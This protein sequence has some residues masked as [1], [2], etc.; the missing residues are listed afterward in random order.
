MK[1]VNYFRS[2]YWSILLIFIFFIILGAITPL[3]GD[4]WTWGSQIGL[5]RL[6]NGYVG[7]NGR[8]FSNTL[9]I[10]ITRAPIIRILTYGVVSTLLVYFSSRIVIPK[11]KL[12]SWNYLFTTAL[13]LTISTP[14]FSQ[15]FGWIAG[16]INYTLGM[17]LICVYIYWIKI[18]TYST[19]KSLPLFLHCTLL[20]ILG[21]VS[22]LTIEHITIYLLFLSFGSYFYLRKDRRKQKI[23]AFYTTGLVLGSIIMFTNPIY[24][25]IFTG[26]DSFRHTA[27]NNLLQQTI[28]TYANQMAKYIFQQ[29]GILLLILTISIILL[30]YKNDFGNALLKWIVSFIMLGYSII[31]AFIRN[32]FPASNFNVQ[33][34]NMLFAIMSLLFI[35][36]LLISITF[37][38]R[39][40]G[41][42][43]RLWFYIFSAL[44]LS[45]PFVVITPYGPRCAFNTI[46][47]IILAVLDLVVTVSADTISFNLVVPHLA[48]LFGVFSMLFILVIMGSNFKV[49][50]NRSPIIKNQLSKN[51]KIIYVRE[52]PFQQYVWDSAP[53]PQRFQYSMYKKRMHISNS[54]KLIFVPFSKWNTK[55]NN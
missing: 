53:A 1:K 49:S 11:E 28:N 23:N 33:N 5:N 54:Q 29:N 38:I 55:I 46:G 48:K 25:R 50:Q 12:N 39:N 52:L 41:L 45:A 47:F 24:T 44:L 19:S 51:S 18:S 42:N 10:I 16:Y 6:S 20:F 36:A 14:V 35:A 4:D 43:I 13:Y 34:I 40:N 15:T 30:I 7:Y 9:E 21:V 32:L 26:H 27:N 3:S 17:L 37:L 22:A 31:A 2:S 8:L